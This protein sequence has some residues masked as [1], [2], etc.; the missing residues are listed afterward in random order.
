M[1]ATSSSPTKKEPMTPRWGG[2]VRKTAKM[3]ESNEWAVFEHCDADFSGTISTAELKA[4]F[5]EVLGKA[6]T[7]LSDA[8]LDAFFEAV[9]A[10]R[11]G[12]VDYDEWQTMV[13]LVKKRAAGDVNAKVLGNPRG[14]LKVLRPGSIARDAA[15]MDSE[16]MCKLKTGTLLVLLEEAT[17][18]DGVRRL[19]VDWG[20]TPLTG[21]VFFG[22][23]H[24][25]V[26]AV[27]DGVR[28]VQNALGHPDCDV[29]I[30]VHPVVAFDA[31]WVPQK[32]GSVGMFTGAVTRCPKCGD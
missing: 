30:T 12:F 19:R 22:H 29:P 7:S 23:S 24:Q 25:N 31:T 11:D 10:D 20:A 2:A 21:W 3:L 4:R 32:T 17:L 8:E 9:D 16:K 6:G 26:D 28:Y 15:A 1:G 14:T 5:V 18:D 13:E 27:L